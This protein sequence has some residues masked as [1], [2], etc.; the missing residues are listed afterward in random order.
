[1]GDYV[2]EFVL[3]A[4][5][6]LGQVLRDMPKNRGEW[7]QFKSDAGGT[8]LEPPATYAELSIN[9]KDALIWQFMADH[10]EDIRAEVERVKAEDNGPLVSTKTVKIRA[11]PPKVFAPS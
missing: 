11:N 4:Q 8:E 6:K 1:M 3:E 9:K 2:N 7:G 5:I 10:E